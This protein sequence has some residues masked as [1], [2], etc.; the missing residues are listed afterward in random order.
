MSAAATY[1]EALAALDP[2]GWPAYLDRW[3]GLPGP[4]ANLELARAVADL[5]GPD[6][7]D[8]LIASGD[9]FRTFCGV[10]GLG[11]RAADP[12]VRERLRQHAR[13]AR[14]RVREAAATALQQLGDTDPAALREIVTAWVA[15]PDPLVQRAAVAA[16]CEPRLLDPPEAAALAIEVCASATA[17]LASRSPQAWRLP[18]ARTLRQALGYAWSVAVSADPTRG[19]PAFRALDDD[20]PDDPDVAWIVA[21]NLR[22]RRLARLV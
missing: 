13:D 10:L 8:A 6:L 1:R 22:K 2:A 3:S 19:L 15:D 21:Q 7:H 5:G 4:R 9:E 16:I 17:S 12:V 14:W 18:E 11:A 20:H